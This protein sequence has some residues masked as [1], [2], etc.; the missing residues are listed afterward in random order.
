MPLGDIDAVVQES[1]PVI[2]QFDRDEARNEVRQYMAE[3][4]LNDRHIHPGF[5]WSSQRLPELY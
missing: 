2:W 5:K 3:T 1:E 4:L